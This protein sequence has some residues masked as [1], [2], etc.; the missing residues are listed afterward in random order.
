MI[1]SGLGREEETAGFG[2]VIVGRCE[3]ARARKRETGDWRVDCDFWRER[4]S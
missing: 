3:A 1:A 4:V 2:V